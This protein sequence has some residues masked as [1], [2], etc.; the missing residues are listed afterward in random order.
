LKVRRFEHNVWE[1]KVTIPHLD[2]DKWEA[3]FK[4]PNFI[5]VKAP[6]ICFWE[7]TNILWNPDCHDVRDPKVHPFPADPTTQKAHTMLELAIKKEPL[8]EYNWWEF[9]IPKEKDED[10]DVV[11]DNSVLSG[12]MEKIKKKARR[13]KA[14]KDKHGLKGVVVSWKIAEAGGTQIKKQTDEVPDVESLLQ[15]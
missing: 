7:K 12:P 3:Y 1:I 11:L 2:Y 5:L 15:M 4:Y 9:E 6:S 10:T 14:P 13:L 8:R